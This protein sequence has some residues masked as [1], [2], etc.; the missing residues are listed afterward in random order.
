M[1]LRCAASS[2]RRQRSLPDAWPEEIVPVTIPSKKGDPVVVTRDEHPSRD[3]AGRTLQIEADRAARW[4][5]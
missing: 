1:R 4:H 5:L 2:A 3:N